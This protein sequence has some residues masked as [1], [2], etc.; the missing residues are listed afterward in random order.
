MKKALI[1]GIDG[2]PYELLQGLI[3]KGCMEGLKKII[4]SGYR[5]HRMHASLPDISSVSWTSFMTGANPAEHGIFGFTELALNTYELYFPN[6]RDIKAPLFWQ[7]LREQ[8]RI[9]RS[10]ILNIPNTYPAFPVDGL[11]VSGFVAIDFDKA[12]YP[13]NYIPIL[14]DMG[15][16]IDV[17]LLKAREDRD[18]FYNDLI[19][20]MKIREGI[21]KKL[22]GEEDWDIAVVC[23]TE[24][25]RLHHFFF[26][27]K[28]TPLFD[29][30]YRKVDRFITSIY[31]TAIKRYGDD[32]LFLVLSD[33]GFEKLKTEVN[34]NAYLQEAGILR[35]DK[36]REFYE[37]IDAGTI[38]FAMDPGRIYI[39]YENRYPRGCVKEDGAETVRKKIKEVLFNLKD[40]NGV[41]V[42]SQI[43]E[44]E[45]IY[46]GNFMQQAPDLVCIPRRGYDLKGNLRK[47]NVFTRDIFQGM[48]TWD[49]AVLITPEDIKINKEINIEFP[50]GIIKDYFEKR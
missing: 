49:N 32:I 14:K 27:E 47:D 34:L 38:A 10:I 16:I 7:S 45:D 5:L 4:D 44:K 15:Y 36:T 50:S 29:S 24:T 30:F 8:K 33:H 6:S 46:K 1:I 3:E 28:D 31:N 17:D 18:G 21:S 22:L 26:N 43:F 42:I 13:G 23:I 11:L 39:N 9:K 12:V 37:R 2:V 35:I 41:S 48:H 20:S 40:G 25:D 19:E